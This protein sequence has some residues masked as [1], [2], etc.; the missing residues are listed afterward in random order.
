[1]IHDVQM[2]YYGKRLATCSSDHK[3]KV[4]TLGSEGSEPEEQATLPRH[5]GPVWQVAWAH[6]RFGSLLASCGY[7]RRVCVWKEGADRSWTPILENLDHRGSVNGVAWAPQENGLLLA[8]CSSDSTVRIHSCRTT[9]SMWETEVVD[10]HQIGCNAVA[11]APTNG[12]DD[13][14][15]ASAGCDKLI[16]IWKWSSEAGR[17]DEE[18][19]LEG[20]SDWV[21]DVAWAPANGLPVEMLA[22]CSQDRHVYIWKHDVATSTWSKKLLPEFEDVAWRVSWSI[23]GGILA[24]TTADNKVTLWKERPDGEFVSMSTLDPSSVGMTS[25]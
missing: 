4:F 9:D 24:V 20:H 21:R 7:D 8:S 19:R 25:S 3:I 6:P 18:H 1:M 17:Y 15:F 22:S 16:K 10:T 12:T 13:K 2:D 5:E 14:R 23:T 11:W